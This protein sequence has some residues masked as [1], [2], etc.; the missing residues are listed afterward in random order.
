MQAE[1][2]GVPLLLRA[3]SR[4]R[5]G[6][7]VIAFDPSP[8]EGREAFARALP[9]PGVGA[10][11]AYLGLPLVAYRQPH[12]GVEEITRRQRS[13]YL[14]QLLDPALSDAVRNLAVV[15]SDLRKRLD[16]A[17]DA[18]LGLFGFSA[19]GLAALLALAD[20]PIPIAAAVIVGAGPDA[21]AAVA[22]AERAFGITYQWTPAAR[23]CAARLDF[24]ARA[25]NIAH[26]TPALLVIRGAD[27]EA[28][29]ATGIERLHAALRPNY[30]QAPDRLRF[31]TLTG[32]GHGLDDRGKVAALADDWLSEHLTDW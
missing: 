6:G 16:L 30:V 19:G 23:V 17:P 14:L 28:V 26:G 2:G 1:A 11:K 25:S 15:V 24:P 10:W 4:R 3:P 21:E 29:P 12:G 7:L 31:E 32:V 9:F 27:D 20:R 5:R 22:A 18:P 8:P 13:D